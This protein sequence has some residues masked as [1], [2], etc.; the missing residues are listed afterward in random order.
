[1]RGVVRDPGGTDVDWSSGSPSSSR[2]LNV[3]R[4]GRNHPADIITDMPSPH[5]FDEHP[6][7]KLP[8]TPTLADFTERLAAAGLVAVPMGEEIHVRLSTLEHVRV[9]IGAGGLRCEV[10][11]GTVPRSRALWTLSFAAVAAIAG[12]AYEGPLTGGVL[13]ASLLI[14]VAVVTSGVRYLLADNVITRIHMAWY[15]AQR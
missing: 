6:S 1:M 7:V 3:F 15:A 14:I 8:L 10:W 2:R 13:A 12:F 5:E 9:R 4:C 11:V